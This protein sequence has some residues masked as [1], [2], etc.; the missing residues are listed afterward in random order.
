[1]LQDPGVT[2]SRKRFEEGALCLKIFTE[3]QCGQADV[4]SRDGHSESPHVFV[5][6]SLFFM[7]V[8]PK[9]TN[10]LWKKNVHQLLKDFF[11]LLL[12]KKTTHP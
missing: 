12:G 7:Q 6:H 1:M 9:Q 2:G 10:K 3:L 11:S 8:N 4:V 5:F